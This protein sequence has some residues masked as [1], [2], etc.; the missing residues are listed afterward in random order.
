MNNLFVLVQTAAGLPADGIEEIII[1]FVSAGNIP[2]GNFLY[3][4]HAL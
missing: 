3:T 2:F 4:L 1:F